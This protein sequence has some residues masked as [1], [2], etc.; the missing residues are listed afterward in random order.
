LDPEKTEEE[1]QSAQTTTVEI[2]T[3]TEG[4][5]TSV[6]VPAPSYLPQ[7]GELTMEVLATLPVATSDMTP[8]QLRQLCLDYF[9]LQC[10]VPWVTN[11]DIEDYSATYASSDRAILAKNLYGGIPYQSKGTGNLRGRQATSGDHRFVDT[12]GTHFKIKASGTLEQR[13]A[14]R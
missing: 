2:P 8:A 5:P 10:S 11:M 12:G 14:E 7:N 3:S 13:G 4:F 6:F 9:E 1:T